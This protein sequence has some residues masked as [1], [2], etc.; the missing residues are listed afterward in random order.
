MP[1]SIETDKTIDTGLACLVMLARYHGLPADPDHLR[2]QRGTSD[3]F[4]SRE[5][6]LSAKSPGL[7]AKSVQSAWGRLSKT[8]LP[9]IARHRDGHFFLLA[10][11]EGDKVLIQD[12][13][14]KRPMTL[15]RALFEESW[16]GELILMTRRGGLLG[17]GGKF[18]FSWF[19]PA[20]LK[21]RRLFLEVL[22][23]SFFIQLFALITPLFFQV[24]IDK[25][26]VHRGL[27][28]LDVLPSAC[29]R[30]RSSR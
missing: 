2:H 19:I 7:K 13:L 17:G 14:E 10:R 23:A 21:Y 4:S 15:P 3:D 25:V 29:W 24:V 30:C 9:A 16:S 12:P 26:L 27:T 8:P 1:H 5:I 18:D 28:T 20:M 22:A 6:V 11:A